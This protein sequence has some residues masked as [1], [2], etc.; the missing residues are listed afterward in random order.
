[1]YQSESMEGM[2]VEIV[3]SQ[4]FPVKLQRVSYDFLFWVIVHT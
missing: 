1:M 2:S 4:I 3:A